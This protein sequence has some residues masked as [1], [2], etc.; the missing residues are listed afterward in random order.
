MAVELHY[1]EFSIEAFLRFGK[2]PEKT[3]EVSLVVLLLT[4]LAQIKFCYKKGKK[5]LKQGPVLPNLLLFF[6]TP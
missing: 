1:F 6:Y 2:R 5:A 4:L 3:P